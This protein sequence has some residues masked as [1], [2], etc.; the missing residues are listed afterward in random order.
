VTALDIT[1]VKRPKYSAAE[2]RKRIQESAIGS[3]DSEEALVGATCADLQNDFPEAPGT[4][5]PI[6]GGGRIAIDSQVTFAAIE[7][8]MHKGAGWPGGRGLGCGHAGEVEFIIA[9]IAHEMN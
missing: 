7:L 9:V 1:G 2:R 4:A 6:L 3:T 5:A 8:H